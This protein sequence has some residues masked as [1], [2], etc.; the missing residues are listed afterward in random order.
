MPNE[1]TKKKK[2][3]V[4]DSNKDKDLINNRF[5]GIPTTATTASKTEVTAI[6]ALV[7]PI[8]RH[9]YIL[10]ILDRITRDNNLT[11]FYCFF[12][13]NDFFYDCLKSIKYICCKLL[14]LINW[15]YFT[16]NGKRKLENVNPSTSLCT[17]ALFPTKKKNKI[18]YKL[19]I[20]IFPYIQ[21]SF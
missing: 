1:W 13:L 18:K 7:K 8:V 10:V 9:L 14:I 12:K 21:S 15:Q 4:W 6:T 16:T 3:T 5:D 17:H 2:K 11:S 19:N 20:C